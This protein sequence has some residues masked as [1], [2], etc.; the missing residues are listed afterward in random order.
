MGLANNRFSTPVTM[1]LRS[2][3]PDDLSR[4]GFSIRILLKRGGSNARSRLSRRPSS[5]ILA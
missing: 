3:E 5:Q 4:A 2:R 1:E